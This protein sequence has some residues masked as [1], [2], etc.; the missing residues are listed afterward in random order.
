MSALGTLSVVDGELLALVRASS[1]FDEPFYRAQAGLPEDTDAVEH[2]LLVGW[3][4][5]LEPNQGFDGSFL[6]PFYETAGFSE[7]P[8]LTWLELAAMG[9]PMPKNRA[10]AEALARPVRQNPLFDAQ[11]YARRL[12]ADM[13]AA[14]HYVIV[15]ER[16]GWR[17][18]S[19]FDPTYYLDRYPDVVASQVSPLSH[20]AA[21]GQREMRPSVPIADRLSFTPL[22]RDGLPVVLV[23][24]HEASRT[25]APIVGWN[26]ARS[27]SSRYSVVSV[28]MRGGELEP[29]F[30]NTSAAVVGPLTCEAHQSIEIRRIA[31]RLVDVYQ[32]LYAVANSIC[33]HQIIPPLV[34]LGVP[35]VALVHEFTAYTRPFE[36]MRDAY[37]W[38]THIVFP[39]RIVAESS[40]RT[41]PDLRSRTGIHVMTQGRAE[42]PAF[43]ASA[44]SV[45]GTAGSVPNVLADAEG[46][47]VVL[48][49]GTVEIRKGVDLFVTAAAA[50]RRL[51][52]LTKFRFVWIGHGYDPTNDNR[53]CSYLAEQIIHSD[54]GDS[55][56]IM[57]PVRDL[58]PFYCRADIFFM[59]SRLDPQPNVG[60][61]ALVRGVP[62]VCFED[63]CGTAEVLTADPETRHLVVPH[64]DAHAAAEEICRLADMGDG[65]ASVCAAV[66][67]VGRAAYDMEGYIRRLDALGR[68]AAELIHQEDLET[69]VTSG[70]V[71]PLMLMPPST[72]IPPPVELERVAI[73]RGKLWDAPEGLLV[74]RP[75]AGFHPQIYAQAHAADCVVGRRDP[76]AH[77]VRHG[78]VCGPWS[79]V[80][81]SPLDTWP[82]VR[83][84]P[85]VALHGHFY[86]P[87]LATDLAHRLTRN[88]TPVDLFLTTDQNEKAKQ[89]HRVFRKHRGMLSVQVWPNRGRDI[90]PL[91]TG[92]ADQITSGGYDVF[93]HVHSKSS[94]A[95]N[96][97]MGK[98]WCDFLWENLIGG[99]HAMLDLAAA[100]F[101]AKDSIGL[102]IAEDPHLI[103]WSENRAIAE[104]IAARMGIATPLDELFDFPLGT[105]FWARPAAL[106]PLLTLRLNWDDYPAEPVPYDGTILHALERLI[107]FATR[108]AGLE[109]AGLRVPGTTW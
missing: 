15:G 102:L 12:P 84:M 86:Y 88:R 37:D 69:L 39:A 71:D 58:E 106:Q 36:K 57:D 48:G 94:V 10:E 61:D 8:V 6:R 108:H 23:V 25:G 17:P 96:A 52:P 81:F 45:E 89:L 44:T 20:F 63:A 51:R 87:E 9:G 59:S 41:F 24:S 46:H 93:G 74:R 55:F 65:I 7:P 1:C 56:V 78:R 18:S 3:Q 79:R 31:E 104:D 68:D 38:A 92:L 5:G 82:S 66:A 76:L 99:D 26:V 103:A 33:T 101:A 91:L 107:P 47:F 97:A 19:G 90:G 28:L 105:M 14:L 34:A 49:A 21:C 98:S 42:V 40:F 22:P 30:S 62:T 54:L 27:L 43:R 4:R 75:C 67:R 95:I 109:V 16:M 35:T 64:L 83:A 80:V 60:I 53:Y 72:E 2:H 50:A 70:A 77:W 11:G 32:P 85:R 13:D 73:L 100:A 29:D